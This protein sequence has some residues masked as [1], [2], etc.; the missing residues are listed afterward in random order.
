MCGPVTDGWS[1]QDNLLPKFHRILGNEVTVI[2]SRWVY[3]EK[4]R[5]TRTGKSVYMNQDNVKVVRLESKYGTNTL[6][7]FKFYH[8]L[9]ASIKSCKPDIIFIHGCQFLDIMR[10]VKYAKEY[11][12][13]KIYVD[14]HADFSNS[15][16][17]WL[18]RNILHRLIWRYCAQKI[19]PY[20]TKFYGVLPA[21][22]DFLADMYGISKS[23]IELLVMGADDEL[24]AAAKSAEVRN[25]IRKKYGINDDDFLIMTGGKI[26]A[27]KKQTLLLMEAVKRINRED[28]KLIVFGSL[29]SD[30][31]LAVESSC[32]GATVQYI[33]WISSDE[34]Y[35]HFA[36]ADLVV[37]PGRHSV[38]WEQV[39]G[40]G[41]PMIVKYWE[42]TTHVDVGGNCDFLYEDSAD[43]IQNKI[44][45]L[46]DDPV[47]Y[48]EMQRV[49][50]TRGMDIFSY[51]KI[52]ERSIEVK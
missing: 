7:K 44:Q 12:N 9:S 21:R 15:A 46:I 48:K 22:V 37:F 27:A 52:A 2:A 32:C 50:E 42:G 24:V 8:G 47:R 10:I 51:R 13:V 43:E 18:S 20:T 49:A 30:L 25:S 45:A 11:P 31:K 41:I 16:S 14:N 28:V 29:T 5:L 1:Y 38:F 35:A 6:S 23:K 40:L 3:D 34:S 17:N 19:E 36:A 26:D 4:G 39:V 33:G